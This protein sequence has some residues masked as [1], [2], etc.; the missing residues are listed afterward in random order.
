MA[1]NTQ[2]VH[3]Q[4]WSSRPPACSFSPTRGRCSC[5]GARAAGGAQ[6]PP[7]RGP[8]SFGK[9]T[10]LSNS[11]PSCWC[12]KPSGLLVPGLLPIFISYPHFPLSFP[13]LF[14]AL[15][16]LLSHQPTHFEELSK[17]FT[18]EIPGQCWVPQPSK[19]YFA[20]SNVRESIRKGRSILKLSIRRP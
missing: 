4:L 15:C 11:H 18:V 10:E 14:L 19:Y 17:S 1:R 6:P 5:L 2:L 7:C 12:F 20:L 3:T 13:F 16:Q 8:H 9:G